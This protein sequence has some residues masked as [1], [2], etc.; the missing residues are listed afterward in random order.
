MLCYI[1]LFMLCNTML[2]YIVLHYAMPYITT[3]N[4]ILYYVM[5]YCT[6][7]CCAV[8]CYSQLFHAILI[9]SMML[10]TQYHTL[11]NYISFVTLLQYSK[12]YFKIQSTV[13]QCAVPL[14]LTQS[15]FCLLHEIFSPSGKSLS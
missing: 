3:V 1:Y 15:S 12:Q 4:F 2:F 8:L 6:I 9:L 7:L 14:M 11:C 10:F 13:G 5:L